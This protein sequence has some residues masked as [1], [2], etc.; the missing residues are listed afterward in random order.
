MQSD[1]L[2]TGFSILHQLDETVSCGWLRIHATHHLRN[3]RT[4]RFPCKYQQTMV[5]D[6][7]KVVQDFVQPQYEHRDT[8][9]V[10][11]WRENV[12]CCVFSPQ[13]TMHPHSFH[14]TF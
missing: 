9:S 8:P 3:P 13:Q 10:G 1:S 11:N 7:F 12:E 4:I 5:S 2:A 14:K 6:G